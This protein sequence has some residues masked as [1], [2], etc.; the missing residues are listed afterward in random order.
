MIGLFCQ[1]LNNIYNR[2]IPFLFVAVPYGTD[3]L[4]FEDFD[5]I[6]FCHI[7]RLLIVTNIPVRNELSYNYRL[8]F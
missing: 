5:C 6:L 8:S 3:F 4:F 1:Y 7:T 2:E